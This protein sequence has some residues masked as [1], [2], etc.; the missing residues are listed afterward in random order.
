MIQAYYCNIVARNKRKSK[1][2]QTKYPINPNHFHLQNKNVGLFLLSISE[3]L[4][5]IF[6]TKENKKKEK[7]KA[8]TVLYEG[9]SPM[10]TSR[11]VQAVR[12]R[13]LSRG[14]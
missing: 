7:E 5:T 11:A 9:D 1:K 8:K 2:C 4:V 13:R 14:K 10:E 3:T 12:S 6:L